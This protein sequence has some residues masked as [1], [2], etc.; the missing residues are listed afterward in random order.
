MI[1]S[2]SDGLGLVWSEA[3][4]SFQV[5]GVGLVL[6]GLVNLGGLF[7]LGGLAFVL[8]LSGLSGD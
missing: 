6:W 2:H 7:L 8:R 1:R 4:L 5:G 3:A